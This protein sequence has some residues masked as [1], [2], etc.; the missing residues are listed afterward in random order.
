MMIVS[1]FFADK[2][3]NHFLRNDPQTPDAALYIGLLKAIPKP[4]SNT[5]SEVAAVG[6]YAR[7]TIPWSDPAGSPDT[8]NSSAVIFNTPDGADWADASDP[9]VAVGMFDQLS[10]GGGNWLLA[11]TICPKIVLNADPAPR[12]EINGISAYFGHRG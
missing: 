12:F 10:L 2:I 4:E 7:E 9:I 6:D 5:T 3:I 11:W 1:Y 8:Y